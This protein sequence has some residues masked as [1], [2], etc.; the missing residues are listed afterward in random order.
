MFLEPLEDRF[1]PSVS[2]INPGAQ[3]NRDADAVSLWLS[4][5]DSGG[6][7]VAFSATGLPPGLAVGNGT[8]AISGTVAAN[9]DTSSPYQVSVTATDGIDSD[10]QNFAW[11][12]TQNNQD[13]NQ[14]VVTLSQPADQTNQVA[15]TVSVGLSATDSGGLPVTYSASGLPA[16]LTLNNSSG[17]ISGTI[18]NNADVGSP[19]TISVGATDGVVSDSKNFTW[20]VTS[21]VVTLSQPPDQINQ[22]GDTVSVGLSASDSAGFA[23]TASSPRPSLTTCASTTSIA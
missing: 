20:T 4:A 3:N 21:S 6:N 18:G 5:T 16:G 8:A 10:T 9:A 7:A 22:D 13:A 17:V 23:L 15:D 11:T 2:L 12:V 1:L 14:L 19:Y